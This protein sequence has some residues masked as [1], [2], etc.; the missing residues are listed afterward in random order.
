[1]PARVRHTH[2]WNTG[3]GEM[4]YRQ[5]ND[6]GTPTPEAVQDVLGVFA[7]INGLAREG[8]TGKRA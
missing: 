7:T 6:F 4:V 5:T 8:K 3:T 2:P 1:M